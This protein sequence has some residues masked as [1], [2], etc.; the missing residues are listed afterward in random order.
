MAWEN[1]CSTVPGVAAAAD[2]S[3]HQ[4]KIVKMSATGIAV[5][6]AGQASI[7]VLQNKP[8]ALGQAATVWGPGSTTKVVAGALTAKGAYVTPDGNGKAVAA[9]TGDHIIGQL[10]DAAGAADNLVTL[11]INPQGRSA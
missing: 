4:F 8:S 3:T 11:F 2:L 1:V 6:G 5:A 7:G 10:L 9:T